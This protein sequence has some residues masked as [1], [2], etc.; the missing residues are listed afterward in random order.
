MHSKNK[1]WLITH[2][3]FFRAKKVGKKCLKTHSRHFPY[4]KFTPQAKKYPFLGIYSPTWPLRSTSKLYIL[5]S[6]YQLICSTC[7][8][9]CSVWYPTWLRLVFSIFHLWSQFFIQ[10][11]MKKP[12]IA[13]RSCSIVFHSVPLF[14]RDILFHSDSFLALYS[15]LALVLFLFFLQTKF[16]CLFLFKLLYPFSL[17]FSLIKF[18]DFFLSFCNSDFVFLLYQITYML[19]E[20]VYFLVALKF[21]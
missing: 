13:K 5:C 15:T 21:F 4:F 8:R 7:A 14:H 17:V 16:L 19:S 3:F 2:A 20:Y 6:L 1:K 12:E 9:F 10:P 18:C 11:E